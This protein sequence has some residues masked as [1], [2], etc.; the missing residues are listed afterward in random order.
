MKNDSVYLKHVLES[1]QLIEEYICN[2]SREDFYKSK[3]IQ[4]AVI[5]RFE[6]IGEAT[7]NI[8]PLFKSRYNRVP[9][10]EMAGMRNVL[11]HEYFGVDLQ[12]VWDTCIN[13]LPSLK[14]QV[15]EMLE[16]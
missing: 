15:L 8:S 13:D 10:R 16:F 7:K 1:I 14:K 4:D 2:I 11:I 9:W 6:I 3:Q 5:R 12:D